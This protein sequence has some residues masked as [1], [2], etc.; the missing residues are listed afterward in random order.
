MKQRYNPD[1]PE[2]MPSDAAARGAL[3]RDAQH[4]V[5]MSFSGPFWQL[6]EWLGFEMLCETFIDDPDWIREMIAFWQDY[7]VRLMEN[8]FPFVIPD[9]VH[10]SEDMAYKAHP[11]IGPDMVREFL[12]P[13]YRQWGELL[14]RYDVPV[15]G[16]D[17]DGDVSTLIPIW[18]E[19][20]VN[21]IDPM[22]VAAG[23]DLPVLRALYGK[24]MGFRGGIDKRCIIAGGQQ[25]VNEIDR[26]KTVMKSGGFI[27]GCDHGV[28]SD[29]SWPNYVRYVELLA[30][31]TGW[32]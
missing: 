32:L 18:I 29:V 16:I 21:V 24:R 17:S 23:I 9:H 13:C 7:I 1:D 25:I 11:M 10:F 31:A 3:L 27:P 22:E 2:R 14:R 15:Y 4:P 30:R 19:A 26:L 20:G 8:A 5:L 12:L 6:R 28:P